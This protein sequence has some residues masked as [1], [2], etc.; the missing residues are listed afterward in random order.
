MKDIRVLITAAGS[1]SAPGLIKS[2]KN[3]GEREVYVVGTD[4][5]S[6][7][8]ILQMADKCRLVPASDAPEYTDVLL[9]ICEEEKID[10]LIPGVSAELMG[11]SR[12]KSEFE[13]IGT[14]VSVSNPFSIDV[15]NNKFLLYDFMKKA[16]LKTPQFYRVQN[17]QDLK[18]A[19]VKLGYPEKGLCVKATE[20]SGSRGIRIIDPAKSRFDI[21]FGEKPNSFYISLEELLLILG[22]K[23]TM[24]EMM[25]M[26]Y[27]PGEEYSVD[28]LADDGKILYMAGRESNVILASIPQMATLRENEKAYKIAEDVV[29]ELK[30]DGNVDLDFKMD[31]NGE[32]VLM[33]IN[34][35]LAATLAV[36]TAGGMNLLYLRVK[37]LLG[38]ELPEVKI[39]YGTV[40]KRR[41]LEQF[42]NSKGEPV[43]I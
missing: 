36:F 6:D 13:A 19:C 16:G 33:E 10:V 40:M 30:L 3:N 2:L 43:F 17:V 27:L 28:V 42:I 25:A 15:A 34:A 8:T 9:G 41:Y 32:P 12:R 24:P 26:E 11:L 39:D 21:L 37:Q 29:R 22:E 38:E 23:E 18:D 35:R 1:P 7:P 31:A 14:K 4:M 5:K 20:S